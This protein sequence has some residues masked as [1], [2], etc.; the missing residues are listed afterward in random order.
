MR[1]VT[2]MLAAAAMAACVANSSRVTPEVERWL[3]SY[4]EVTVMTLKTRNVRQVGAATCGEATFELNGF[5]NDYR[6]FVYVPNGESIFAVGEGMALH[7]SPRCPASDEI[8]SIC[9]PTA[10][11]R[12]RAQ[13]RHTRCQMHAPL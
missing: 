4:M 7:D 12:E 3:S 5:Q 13:L 8:L 11:G 9:A 10:A 6:P 2:I 1:S